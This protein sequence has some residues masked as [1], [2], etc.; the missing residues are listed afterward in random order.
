MIHWCIVSLAVAAFVWYILRCIIRKVTSNDDLVLYIDEFSGNIFSGVFIMELGVIAAA[1]G[2][3]SVTHV[4][5]GFI[6]LFIRNIY[7]TYESVCVFVDVYYVNGKKFTLSIF[8]YAAN[9]F[10]QISG[11][12]LGQYLARFF[13]AFEDHAHTEAMKIA[14]E[15]AISA[16]HSCHYIA[17][18]EFL[19]PFTMCLAAYFVPSRLVPFT[20]TTVA[21]INFYF[22]THI[23]GSFY[24]QSMSTAFTFQCKGHRSDLEFFG[25]YW[26]APTMGSV[27]AWELLLA[28]ERLLKGGKTE[29][30]E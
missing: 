5:C 8:H 13:W 3:Y 19:G 9:I 6:M 17:F 16:S 30:V 26:V 27:V 10:C 14:C 29:K 4:A 18:A 22:F 1:Y 21:F 25:V 2:N 23:S 28:G 11:M 20:V 7:F 12:V 15:T 24:N